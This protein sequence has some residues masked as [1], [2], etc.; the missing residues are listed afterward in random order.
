LAAFSLF[1]YSSCDFFIFTSLSSFFWVNRIKLGVDC[2][3]VLAVGWRFSL[4]GLD[5]LRGCNSSKIRVWQK[6]SDR[7]DLMD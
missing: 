2:G 4:S 3:V 1:L 5:M 7:K 6:I